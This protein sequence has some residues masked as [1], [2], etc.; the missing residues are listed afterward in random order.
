MGV[1]LFRLDSWTQEAKHHDHYSAIYR[2]R[3]KHPELYPRKQRWRL[4]PFG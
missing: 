4:W 3:A 2:E 1:F